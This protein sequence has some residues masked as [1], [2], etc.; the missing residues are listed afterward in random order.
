MTRQDV[1]NAAREDLAALRRYY[2]D[3][4]WIKVRYQG[5][6]P[7]NVGVFARTGANTCT[8]TLAATDLSSYFRAGR[9][10]KIKDGSGVGVDLVTQ[11]SVNA[12]YLSGVTTITTKAAIN[13]AAT[14]IWANTSSVIRAQGLVES[15]SEWFIPATADSAGIQGAIDAADAAG[16]GIVF[17]NQ[18]SYS[19]GTQID[20]TG[21]KGNVVIWGKHPQVT[22]LRT[23]AINSIINFSNA[24]KSLEI[25]NVKFDGDWLANPTG[26]GY[27]LSVGNCLS[28]LVD[29]CDFA[30]CESGIRFTVSGQ[31]RI[32]IRDSSFTFH[33]YGISTASVAD[34]F[35]GSISGCTFDGTLQSL[36]APASMRLSGA[37]AVT[38]NVLRNFSHASLVPTGI[39]IW[40][41]TTGDLGGLRSSVVG[42][43]IVGTA[44]TGIAIWMGTSDGVCN[45]NTITGGSGTTGIKLGSNTASAF[46]ERISCVGNTI[47]AGSLG[48]QVSE[49]CR[50]STIV[51]N[52]IRPN[53]GTGISLGGDLML[54]QGNFIRNCPV[55]ID[56]LATAALPM[57][58][59]NLVTETSSDNII[60]R[61]SSS[62]VAVM[63][64]FLPGTPTRGI[65][66]ELNALDAGVFN[67][68]APALASPLTNLSTTTRFARNRE[69][70]FSVV[71][72]GL[73]TAL[74]GG[75]GAET[76]LVTTPLPGD[77]GIGTYLVHFSSRAATGEFQYLI[78]TGPLGT[79]A[80][81]IVFTS[82]T[83]N[84]GAAP[85]HSLYYDGALTFTI[86]DA[87]TVT[88]NVM[89][90]RTNGTAT[91]I[92]W[93]IMVTKLSEPLG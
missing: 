6:L 93:G 86:T 24:T 21:T 68:Y 47:A 79:I 36:P 5:P 88:M 78:R 90:K 89:G 49:F 25:R 9:V 69:I 53:S 35:E 64:N 19:I 20:I 38:G 61:A 60:V 4:E 30:R 34:T 72:S 66:V 45:G 1:N 3:P 15:S 91:T 65:N 44:A 22:L 55:G 37:W 8:I 76:I 12:T 48:I 28:L 63:N 17:L 77:G 82:K 71:H 39:Y 26:N 81:P 16:G 56:V 74:P 27:G 52:A 46:A 43:V 51:G 42:N 87:T 84:A 83:L 58:S 10:V 32:V 18:S 92:D 11:C 50:Q 75:F 73:A 23:A 41:R 85:E 14:D 62:G 2:N 80:D 70:P 40:D 7:A 67:N 13:V 59:N 33:R 29:Q 57:I 54:V 31:K